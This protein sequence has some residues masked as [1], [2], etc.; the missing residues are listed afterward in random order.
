MFAKQIN[1]MLQE[2]GEDAKTQAK[3]QPRYNSKKLS[4]YIQ[5]HSRVK[6]LRKFLNVIFDL[7]DSNK[8]NGIYSSKIAFISDAGMILMQFFNQCVCLI[9]Y[10][11]SSLFAVQC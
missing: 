9:L 3:N 1:A 6:Q 8:R 10:I 11:A 5:F 4:D 2:F 7:L